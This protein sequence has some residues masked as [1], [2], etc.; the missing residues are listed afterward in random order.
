MTHCAEDGC[1]FQFRS[2]SGPAQKE[3]SATHVATPNEINGE[4]QAFAEGGDEHV[5]V[6]AGPNA[7]KEDGF[8]VAA[9]FG[10]ELLGVL[11]NGAAIANVLMVDLNRG[12]ST[13]IV[14]RK[15]SV[16]VDQASVGSDDED[17]RGCARWL[18]EGASVSHFAAEIEAA[19]ESK[20]FAD[21]H[22][23]ATLQTTREVEP[24][25]RIKD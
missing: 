21:G 11:L 20:D 5:H 8:A 13:Q 17:A 14:D 3:P 24:S 19:K 22:H 7:S 12:E 25:A 16:G 4:L 1:V 2:V 6:F 23:S 18:G 15:R 10:G 9:E